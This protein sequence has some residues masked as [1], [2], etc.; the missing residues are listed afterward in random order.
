MY[1][2]KTLIE[3]GV[4]A[5]SHMYNDYFHPEI[6]V[7]AS[8]TD[9]Q[10]QNNIK[11][12]LEHIFDPARCISSI[13]KHKITIICIIII[14]LVLKKTTF[15]FIYI[16]LCYSFCFY[17]FRLLLDYVSRF[18]YS[19]CFSHEVLLDKFS[20]DVVLAIYVV[21]SLFASI[22]IFHYFMILV[23]KLLRVIFKVTSMQFTTCIIIMTSVIVL[24]F[25]IEHIQFKIQELAVQKI[26][27][28]IR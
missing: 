8:Q 23:E 10:F 11:M 28:H 2:N 13:L 26:I 3:F 14:I 7:L 12:I 17:L 16:V 21:F 5:I 24:D 22:I 15:S 9:F 6:I 1:D 25:I 27:Q 19:Y 18:A 20:Y 4:V